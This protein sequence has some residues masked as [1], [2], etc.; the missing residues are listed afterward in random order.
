[1]TTTTARAPSLLQPAFV[2]VVKI[3][4]FH[5]L[6][7]SF[8]PHA[9]ILLM[10][11]LLLITARI[12]NS[13]Q[14]IHTVVAALS[15]SSCT[16]CWLLL[17]QHD[18]NAT[19]PWMWYC[20]VGLCIR[21]KSRRCWSR[22]SLSR[23]PLLSR[24]VSKFVSRCLTDWKTCDQWGL[25]TRSGFGLYFAR[26]WSIRLWSAPWPMLVV[27]IASVASNLVWEKYWWSGAFVASTS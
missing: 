10:V 14:K 17:W 18:G 7:P 6:R 8:L 23:C 19:M 5:L 27:I 25:S 24:N 15:L 12:S 11:M 26:E 16:A 13:G 2:V 9:D 1:M 20:G 4:D 3:V 21:R 22:C